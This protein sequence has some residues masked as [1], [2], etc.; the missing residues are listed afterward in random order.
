MPVDY[1]EPT[2]LRIEVLA[3]NSDT[4]ILVKEPTRRTFDV[5]PAPAGQLARPNT[6]LGKPHNLPERQ[7]SL[8][9]DGQY[10]TIEVVTPQQAAQQQKQTD[11]IRTIQ[12]NGLN[13]PGGVTS[14]YARDQA[15]AELGYY[16]GYALDGAFDGIQG[17][18]VPNE[19]LRLKR[20]PLED[21]A[22]QGG[23]RAGNEIRN[24]AKDALDNARKVREDLWKNRPKFQ[25][26]E[27]KIPQIEKPHIPEI[28]LPEIKFPELPKI[29][30]IKIEI[31]PVV[32]PI[33][34]DK[35]RQL[36]ELD[37]TPCGLVIF[38]A[39]YT[40]KVIGEYW[41]EETASF[42]LITEPTS[43]SEI[44]SVI[45][46]CYNQVENPADFLE[47]GG[48]T[49]VVNNIDL[50]N[51]IRARV[52]FNVSGF[53]NENCQPRNPPFGGQ[54][55][56]YYE[57]ASI[58]VEILG[59]NDTSALSTIVEQLDTAIY[60]MEIYDI[61]VSNPNHQACVLTHPPTPEEKPPPKPEEKDCC[62]M[63]CCSKPTTVD[64]AKIQAL[65]QQTLQ[66]A[67]YPVIIPVVNCTFNET[68]GKWEPNTSYITLQVFAT[69]AS[70]A[71]EQAQL[72]LEQAKLATQFCEAKNNTSD[73]GECIASLPERYQL[74]P[75][76]HIPQMVYLFREV[77]E[78]NSLGDDYYPITM[79]HPTNTNA[80]QQTALPNYKKG[81][82]ELILTLKDN[83][84][85]F[86]N[87]YSQEDAE[88]EITAIKSKI[89]STY[90]ENSIQKIG[91][92]KGQALKEI[93][94]KCVR[95]DYYPNGTKNAKPQWV[96][97]FS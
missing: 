48:G 7:N 58:G 69:N 94:V 93:T 52:N 11:Q 95:V 64:Y 1:A 27:I 70:Q 61:Q 26:P 62:D 54:Y 79:P 6:S 96:K 92:R 80:S 24:I 10:R 97:R 63:G 34:K 23:N 53:A 25:I 73:G 16:T 50:G 12:S 57:Y 55:Y 74:S 46:R 84:K 59:R 83:S 86:V 22:Y 76:G 40:R 67:T 85:V 17:K 77:K 56:P 72:H 28:K 51:N 31:K 4:P 18:K 32:R 9:V 66:K 60:P 42:K 68:S 30:Q 38:K 37:I 21:L 88:N 87:A 8:R 3:P 13:A 36:Q 20:T 71:A 2:Q 78:D 45:N 43:I 49:G 91:Q 47:G 44:Q 89:N 35:K 75:D 14:S 41:H 65:M 15:F 90:L 82:W 39:A 33:P 29:P 19:A 5:A 81:S